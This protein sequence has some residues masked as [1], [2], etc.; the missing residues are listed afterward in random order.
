MG[1]RMNIG[2]VRRIVTAAGYLWEEPVIQTAYG[3]TT[4]CWS[5]FSVRHRLL[6][7]IML[8]KQDGKMHYAVVQS[9]KH[10][11]SHRYVMVGILETP[12]DVLNAWGIASGMIDAR[13][14]VTYIV[15]WE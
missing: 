5:W 6:Y 2:R 14:S 10:S 11:N 12:N 3:M 4:M 7:T 9:G 1:V 8:F 15:D 13:R